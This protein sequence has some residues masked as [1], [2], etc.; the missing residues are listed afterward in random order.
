MKSWS[1]FLERNPDIDIAMCRYRK[2][3]E[4]ACKSDLEH[5]EKDFYMLDHDNII[6][7]MFSEQYENFVVVWNKLY[8]RK[9]WDDL[10]FP[11][12]KLREDEFVSYKFL[13]EQKKM[14]IFYD[15]FYNY[16]QRSGSIMA[17][18]EI[19]AF[20]DNTEALEEKIRFFSEK[21]ISGI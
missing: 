19:Q 16:R 14:G 2:V 1:H 5:A 21:K 18:C 3:E 20:W 15:R 13:Y 10:R 11:V 6:K 7:D 9:V 8:R 17:K 4:N 12:G